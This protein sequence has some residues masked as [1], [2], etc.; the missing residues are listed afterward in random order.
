MSTYD[1]N[2]GGIIWTNHA[3][4]RL[5]ERNVKQGDAWAAWKRP[6]DSKY[7]PKKGAWVYKRHFA[8][9]EI[10]IVAKKTEKNEWLVLSVWSKPAS[11][12][13]HRSTPEKSSFIKQILSLFSGK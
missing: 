10:E 13:E 1:R 9:E 6:D 4:Q 8:S 7:D 5:K 11:H 12:S 2:Y 3:L